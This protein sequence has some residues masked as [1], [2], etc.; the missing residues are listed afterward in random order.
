MKSQA[1]YTCPMHPEIRQ[2]DPSV[3]PKCGMRL[4]L[5]PA[6]FKEGENPERL[7]LAPP[8][9]VVVDKPET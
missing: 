2:Y 7:D 9:D 6:T 1:I 3:C 5:V 8:V 4:E